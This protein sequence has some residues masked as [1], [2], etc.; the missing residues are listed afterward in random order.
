M[1]FVC[2]FYCVF[3]FLLCLSSNAFCLPAF[4]GAE[5]FGSDTIGGRGGRVIHV[6]TLADNGDNR[7]P[8]AGSLRAAINASGSRIVVFDVSGIIYL[9][10]ILI[11]R[12]PFI[13]IAGQTSPGGIAT[14][15]HP[16]A[17]WTNDVIMRHMRIRTGSNEVVYER[18]TSSDPDGE[19]EIVCYDNLYS[20]CNQGNKVPCSTPGSPHV[21]RTEGGC[22]GDYVGVNPETLDT[23]YIAGSAM[24]SWFPGATGYNIII[25]HCSFSW[26]VDETFSVVTGA[27]DVTIQWS[28][29]FEGLSYAGH[30]KG[31]HSKGMLCSFKYG[32]VKEI[33]IHHNYFSNSAA[34]QPLIAGGNNGVVDDIYDNWVDVRNNVIFLGYAN[35]NA[36]FE[37][38]GRGNAVNNWTRPSPITRDTAL[39]WSYWGTPYGNH[40]LYLAGNKGAPAVNPS[41]PDWAINDEWRTQPAS[42]DYQRTTPYPIDAIYLP[43]TFEASAAFAECVVA[44]VGATAPS[45]DSV[46]Q[47]MRDEW[48]AGSYTVRNNVKYPDDYPAYQNLTAPLD[49]DQDGMP[50]D[51]ETAHGLRNDQDDSDGDPDGDGYTNIEEYIN[52]L[53]DNSIVFDGRCMRALI[54]PGDIDNDNTV[55][56]VDLILALKIT[57]GTSVPGVHQSADVDADNKIGLEEAVFILQNLAGN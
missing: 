28:S 16:I 32:G 56:L 3:F 11:I 18:G 8:I 34:R 49:S 53:A 26:G 10:S 27:R 4:P 23:F 39:G 9:Q 44:A 2:V 20:N 17:I 52:E 54:Q 36:T 30:P 38:D 12:E 55:D 25:D 33:S 47:R 48:A 45:I 46:D 51:W 37:N 35:G 21:L 5:G 13:T 1:R 15:G 7:N 41:D 29:I 19:G 31:E 22:G 57:A 14:A 42:T 50:D 24:P 40:Y 43:H 6:T